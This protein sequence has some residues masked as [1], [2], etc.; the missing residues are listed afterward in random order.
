MMM[1]KNKVISISK[2]ER[3]KLMVKKVG[4]KGDP[5]AYHQ[6]YVIFIQDGE[7]NKRYLCEITNVCQRNA[8]A[9]I[10]KEIDA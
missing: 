7:V 2:G 10:I 5:M 3:L 1:G 8:F 4:H 9:K 6:N